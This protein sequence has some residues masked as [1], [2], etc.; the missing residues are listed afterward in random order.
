MGALG[1]WGFGGFGV[2]GCRNGAVCSGGIRETLGSFR[3]RDPPHDAVPPQRLQDFET[4]NR[5]SPIQD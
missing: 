1:F 2:G 4:E 5:P 3:F